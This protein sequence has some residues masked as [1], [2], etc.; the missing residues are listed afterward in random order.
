V[1]TD[2]TVFVAHGAGD[3]S[4][5]FAINGESGQIVGSIHA[6][7]MRRADATGE[8]LP[9]SVT[10]TPALSADGRGYIAAE[11]MI[12]AFKTDTGEHLGVY[13]AEFGD[14]GTDPT[15]GSDGT[16]FFGAKD[17]A[18]ALDEDGREK[19]TTSGL[20]GLVGSPAVTSDTVYVLAQS[21]VLYALDVQTG[22]R[23]WE[24]NTGRRARSSPAV[25]DDG[26]VYIATG[27]L[28]AL[29]P[30]GTRQWE[31]DPPTGMSPEGE[32]QSSPAIGPDGVL[33]LG[34]G[35][36]VYA[37]DPN[38]TEKWRRET[39]GLVASSPAVDAAGVVYATS[40][41]G[42][43]YALFGRSGNVKWQFEAGSPLVSSPAIGPA[44]VVYFLAYDGGTVRG[45][46][47]H[48]ALFAIGVGAAAD[49]SSTSASPQT[50]PQR[51]AAPGNQ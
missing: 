20:G 37:I 46:A 26:T 24:F 21:G 2:G 36:A 13:R 6:Y 44:G 42:S 1:A 38:G 43:L 14:I 48:P 17:T 11:D 33:Y 40:R 51:P 8:P 5:V 29:S 45:R 22:R 35:S 30:Q 16:I 9:A 39:K 50:G 12:L 41:D 27:K 23:K 31:F 47:I 4:A 7:S 34:M 10:G 25:A 3:K 49:A 19:W 28:H 32:L 15:V 18:I